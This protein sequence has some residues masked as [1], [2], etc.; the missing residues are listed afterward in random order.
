MIFKNHLIYIYIY[1]INSLCILKMPMCIKN[2]NLCNYGIIQVFTVNI[3]LIYNNK[4][5][6]I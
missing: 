3:L 5:T 6:K 1:I 4:K 2:V